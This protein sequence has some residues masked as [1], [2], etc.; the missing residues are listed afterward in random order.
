MKSP[1]GY[2]PSRLFRAAAESVEPADG[3]AQPLSFCPGPREDP[4]YPDPTQENQDSAAKRACLRGCEVE[5]AGNRELL[6]DL[7]HWSCRQR[8]IAVR[9]AL[10]QRFGVVG[11][12]WWRSSSGKGWHVVV[13]LGVD[14]PAPERIALEAACG[15]DP[16]R[17]IL[18]VKAIANG[19]ASPSMLFRPSDEPVLAR[20]S[21]RAIAANPGPLGLDAL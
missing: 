5:R 4:A 8:Y 20:G 2:A 3:H 17:A 15:S 9:P 10:N 14:I 1:E 7:D 13:T 19:I 18:S 11:E 16:Y 6:L 12:S 21:G